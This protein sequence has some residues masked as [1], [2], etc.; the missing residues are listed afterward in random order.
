MSI[1]Q[2]VSASNALE[3]GERFA[4]DLDSGMLPR[5]GELAP[6]SMRADLSLRV[7]AARRNWLEGRIVGRLRLTCQK[8]MEPF[9]WK[10]DTS[11][12]VVLAASEDEEASLM[13]DCDP[14][15]VSDDRLML[16]EIV[17]DEVLLALPMM[18]RCPA[19]ENVAPAAHPS[20][21]APSGKSGALA[22]LKDLS[23]KGGAA[24]RRK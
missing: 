13:A 7:D 21:S 11:L 16:Y 5:L 12:A 23:L 20:S 9:S 14:V 18:P 19:C 22:S 15:L 2:R 3:R 24:A 17:E 4:G 1:P 8:C 6:A 10:L